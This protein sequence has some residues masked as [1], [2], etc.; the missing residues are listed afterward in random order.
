MRTLISLYF[1]LLCGLVTALTGLMLFPV[2]LQIVSRYSSLVPT[3]MWTEEAARFCLVWIIM[4]GSAVAVRLR[5]HF[6][7][8]LLP[9]P[10]TR[11]GQVVS[12]L[13][14]D[15]VVAGFGAAFLWIGAGYTADARFEVSEITEMPMI[16]MYAAFPMAA[17]GW[18]LFLGEQIVDDLVSLARSAQ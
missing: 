2:T 8:D 3:F 6:D 17:A 12:R 10:K 15:L 4:L 9:Q 16:Y 18:L 5:A 7:I 11:A 13:V 14:V 1:R